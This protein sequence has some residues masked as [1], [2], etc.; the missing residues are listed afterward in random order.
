MDETSAPRTSRTFFAFDH[1]S[2]AKSDVSTVSVAA[3]CCTPGVLKEDSPDSASLRS[4]WVTPP[5][6][7]TVEPVVSLAWKSTNAQPA[8][9]TKALAKIT[10]RG[11][12]FFTRELSE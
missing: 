8:N 2:P 12:F 11:G 1:F 4:A 10:A 7:V 3:F 9:T 6:G 5:P